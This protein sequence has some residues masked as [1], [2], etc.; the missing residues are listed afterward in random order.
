MRFK[1]SGMPRHTGKWVHGSMRVHGSMQVHRSM[2]VHGPMGPCG[3]MGPTYLVCSRQILLHFCSSRPKK[4]T[5]WKIWRFCFLFIFLNWT[6]T[7]LFYSVTITSLEDCGTSS[8]HQY[9]TFQCFS[10]LGEPLGM[11]FTEWASCVG[12]VARAGFRVCHILS[13]SRPIVID[14][15]NIMQ[16]V[17]WLVKQ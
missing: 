10:L 12:I 4:K 11:F 6:C 14:G 3:Y 8:N 7:M 15:Q 1:K 16:V 9:P 5:T 17:H 2:Q 13:T